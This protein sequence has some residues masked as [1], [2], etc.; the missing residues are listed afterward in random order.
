MGRPTCLLAAALR[1]RRESRVK[2]Q[3][4]ADARLRNIP[5]RDDALTRQP[6]T[7]ALVPAKRPR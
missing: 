2:G 5:E 4:C 7:D 6:C 1:A 3:R